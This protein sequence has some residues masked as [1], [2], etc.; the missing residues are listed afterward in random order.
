MKDGA[1]GHERN[2][3]GARWKISRLSRL[4]RGTKEFE[5]RKVLERRAGGED[6]TIS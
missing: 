1:G 5:M 4:R 6:F 2:R 3:W